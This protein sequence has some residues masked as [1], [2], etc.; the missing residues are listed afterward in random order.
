MIV[1]SLTA[2]V[3]FI[4]GEVANSE[5]RKY[6]NPRAKTEINNLRNFI[7]PSDFNF[8]INRTEIII[9]WFLNSLHSIEMRKKAIGVKTIVLGIAEYRI[10]TKAM[11]GI[12]S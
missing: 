8:Q 10:K 12:K 4:C 5:L 11:A 3:C 7:S 2:R 9:I 1:H 6:R